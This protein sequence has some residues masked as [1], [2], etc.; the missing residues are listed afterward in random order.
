MLK[1]NN[2]SISGDLNNYIK[3]ENRGIINKFILKKINVTLN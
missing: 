1:N 3:S 2:K